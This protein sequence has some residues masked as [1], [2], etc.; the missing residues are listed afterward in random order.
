MASVQVT[1]RFLRW[2][3]MRYRV[4][5]RPAPG[6]DAPPL[7][8]I[9]GY[10]ACVEQWGRFIRD[11]GP[12]V[13]VYAVDLIGYGQSSKPR[14][15]P[16]G[17]GFYIRQLEH[18]RAQYSWER[19]VPV[20]HSM[21][22]MIAIEWAATNPEAVVAAIGVAPGGLYA[23]AEMTP[24]QLRVLD[25]FANPVA[26][27]LLYEL[28]THLPYRVLSAVAYADRAVLDP[29][30]KRALQRAMRSPGAV[31]SYSAPYRNDEA[32]RVVAHAADLRCPLHIIW[33]GADKLLP[34]ENAKLFGAR[35]PQATIAMLEGG[36]HCVHE[37]RAREVAAEV[38]T[39]L[40]LDGLLAP[41]PAPLVVT[42]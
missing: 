37:E 13:P 41:V 40:A 12:D 31:W 22:G 33:G 14:D 27:R 9:H 24:A 34:Y 11:I 18:L 38:R 39:L 1:E 10:A 19:V 28:I 15:V 42:A 17:R 36:G 30:T 2:N 35:F 6:S 3:G 23:Q 5:E 32:F 26:T 7:V 25:V 16:Y 29:V 20:G 8:L 21:G 4:W